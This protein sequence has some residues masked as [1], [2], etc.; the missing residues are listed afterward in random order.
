MTENF[1]HSP[2]ILADLI[3]H[4]KYAKYIP[5][6]KRRETYP[7]TVERSKSMHIK[8]FPFLSNEI[9]EAFEFVH[10]K[11]ILPSMRG[12]QFGGLAIEKNNARM[13]NCS[14]CQIDDPIVFQEIMFLLLSGCG[15]GYSV[16]F[17]HI[18]KL[19]KIQKPGPP[20]KFIIHDSI[21][22][23]AESINALMTAYFYGN[24]FPLF[25]YDEIRPEGSPLITSGG[26]APGP[27]PLKTTHQNMLNILTQIP[28]G[29]KLK[30]IQAHDLLCF[31]SNAVLSGG[32]RRSSFISLFSKNDKEMMNC[33]NG[34]WWKENPQRALA[35]NSAMVLRQEL[36]K[37]L[38]ETIWDTLY[39]SHNGEPNIY[40]TNS[41]EYGTNPC[42]GKTEKLLTIDG[43][44]TFQE[45]AKSKKPI[46]IINS[47]GNIVKTKVWCSGKKQT[48]KLKT[49]MNE[50]ITCTPEH[51]FRTTNNQ[52]IQAKDTH[53]Q[54]IMPFYFYTP[55]DEQIPITILS[56][57]EGKKEEVYDFT[58]P[59]TNWG[60]I[61]PGTSDPQKQ[62]GYLAHNCCEI[63]GENNFL[64]NLVEINAATIENQRDLEERARMASRIATLQA[65]YTHFHF[66][67]PIWQLKAENNSLIG[68]GMTGIASGKVL[69]LDLTTAAKIVVDENVK[70]SKKL[71]IKP[72]KRTTTVKPGGTTSLELGDK[73]PVS[74]GIHSYQAPTYLRR[75]ITTHHEPI[76]NFL[77]NNH[78]YLLEPSAYKPKQE[79]VIT[80]PL[81]A[82]PN[83]I[84]R[85]EG[86]IELLER[87]KK[88]HQ[89]WIIPGHIEGLNT[90]NVSCT[91]S[92]KEDEWDEVKK[93]WWENK[94]NFLSVA[95]LPF[96]GGNYPQLP[97]EECS[98]E[99]YQKRLSEIKPID[100][101]LIKEEQDLTKRQQELAC[102]GGICEL[103]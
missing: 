35:N 5:E 45:L 64:C 43:P 37:N 33:K 100:F 103:V 69:N 52:E 17:Q 98:T 44:K 31:M 93:W 24:N 102:F 58:E 12:F 79:S 81:Q 39:E 70:I 63:S 23:W 78:P 38:F 76:Y 34:N 82:P 50:I 2:K 32:I 97:F 57:L 66:L 9:N 41:L 48:I 14:F 15:V 73:I 55:T 27:E 61:I 60:I 94:N 89:E 42:F 84:T 8:H 26:I 101:S 13:Y 59:Q 47:E 53:N 51:K 88:F 30:T 10:N 3:H 83:A 85:Y 71:N 20:K 86:A 36:D 7:E 95:L 77:K 74:S 65:S 49:S 68:V 16:Q 21:E 4:T 54:Q 90:N 40:Q 22:G 75:I 18:N 92:V 29:Q 11:Q 99:E 67:R 96:D 46:F 1:V 19:P 25:I 62:I 80:F 6:K 56:I 91:I 87:I 72:A 28:Y